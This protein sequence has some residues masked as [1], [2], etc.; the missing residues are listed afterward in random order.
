MTVEGP[1]ECLD[2]AILPPT[3]LE[4]VVSTQQIQA[5]EQAVGIFSAEDLVPGPALCLLHSF[6][7]HVLLQR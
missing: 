7:R 6:H 1:P 4:D 2:T 3:V 5:L